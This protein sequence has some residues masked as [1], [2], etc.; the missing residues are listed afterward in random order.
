MKILVTGAAGFIGSH[1][2]ERLLTEGED[3]IGVDNLS[4]GSLAN[5]ATARSSQTGKFSFQRVDVTSNAVADLIKRVKPELVIHLAA[6]IDIA[7]SI[8]DPLTDAT[9]NLLGTI[10]VLEAAAASGARKVVA[11][12]SCVAVEPVPGSPYAISRR[13]GHEYLRYYGSARGLAYTGLV[14]SDVYGP[15]QLPNE[16]S[17]GG[18]V[19]FVVDKMLSRRPCT[20]HG[21][22]TDTRDLVYVDDVAA[23]F[24]AAVDAG[25]GE[26][27]EIGSGTAC[28]LEGLHAEIAALTSSRFDPIFATGGTHR[29][30]SAVDTSRATE[31]LGWSQSTPLTEGL[32]QTVAWYRG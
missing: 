25:D 11:G 28:T 29:S 6:N 17:E 15:R 13:A 26:F 16:G 4:S 19:A 30:S 31:V 8:S 12:S 18:L 14:L 32:K 3:V 24:T 10:N 1:V 23:A 9:V 2:V 27:L 20:I 7:G 22:A 5:L 21:H